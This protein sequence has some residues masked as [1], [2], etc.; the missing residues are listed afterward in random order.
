VACQRKRAGD[1][2]RLVQPKFRNHGAS[3]HAEA[4][5]ADCYSA[6]LAP[7]GAGAAAVH[8]DL[9]RIGDALSCHP[10]VAG[11]RDEDAPR[12]QRPG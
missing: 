12:K 8:G 4:I 10:Q 7:Q 5:Q 9:G 2:R 6:A 3:S 1:R 11:G